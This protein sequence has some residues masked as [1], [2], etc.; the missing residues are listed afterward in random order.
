MGTQIIALLGA[1]DPEMQT[2]NSLL[3]KACIRAI[4]ATKDGV[5]VHPGNA[6]ACD[7][8]A[9][10]PLGATLFLVEC[11]PN[12]MPEDQEVVVF[13]HHR[14]GD[15]GY[16]K[17]P[18]EYWE[19][20]SLGQLLAYMH[21]EL[22]CAVDIMQDMRVVAAMD[23]CFGAALQ[24]ACPSVSREEV[25]EAKY[26]HIARGTGYS[27]LAVENKTKQFRERLEAAPLVEL[28]GCQ[29]HDLREIDLGVGYSVDLLTAQLAAALLEVPALFC[30]RDTANA[31]TKNTLYNAPPEAVQ[32]FMEVWAPAQGLGQI[33]GVPTRGY[34]GGYLLGA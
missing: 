5:P 8:P 32:H 33:Y 24:G 19:A 25:L 6:Y 18:A 11:E 28:G 10:V 9:E 4:H 30:H 13:D 17:G 20:S 3:Q 31:P 7:F 26:E 23:H 34:A 2:I 29:V 12:E 1:S 27:P 14:P 22:G 21:D 16:G 15:P